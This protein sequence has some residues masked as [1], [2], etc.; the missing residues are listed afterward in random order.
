V[1]FC[2]FKQRKQQQQQQQQH[3]SLKGMKMNNPEW[4]FFAWNSF[5]KYI[6]IRKVAFTNFRRKWSTKW[7][8]NI[9]FFVL[10][11][12]FVYSACDSEHY[13]V[14]CANECACGAGAEKCDPVTGCVCK[15]GW[16]G[17][18]CDVDRNECVD[19]PCTVANTECV[20]I[21]GSYQCPCKSGYKE[22]ANKICEG[23]CIF[24]L[25]YDI[26]IIKYFSTHVHSLSEVICRTS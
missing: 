23:A 18:K 9:F 5:T 4:P 10:Y 25:Y 3:Q 2:Y 24:I 20:N 21:P 13:G 11:L 12:S 17:D 22:N 1:S 26:C 6:I 19:S 14:N 7:R 16:S 15:E 8:I